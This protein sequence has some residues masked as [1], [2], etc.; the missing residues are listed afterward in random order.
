MILSDD[1]P[2]TAMFING[3]LVHISSGIELKAGKSLETI[4]DNLITLLNVNG[5]STRILTTTK[6]NIFTKEKNPIT[7]YALNH[8]G[9]DSYYMLTVLH[10]LDYNTRLSMA[11]M[12]EEEMSLRHPK[13]FKL[14]K[15]VVY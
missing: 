12:S 13:I 15:P 2:S 11:Y 6:I 8:R 3:K 10:D 14:I 4:M 7:V 9:T 5:N 1:K